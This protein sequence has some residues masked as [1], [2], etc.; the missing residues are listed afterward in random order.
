MFSSN[1]VFAYTC[2]DDHRNDMNQQGWDDDNDHITHEDNHNDTTDEDMLTEN[3][4]D[5]STYRHS[6]QIQMTPALLDIRHFG[7]GRLTNNQQD[8]QAISPPTYT[9][10]PTTT[11]LVVD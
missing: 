7:P 3:T 9:L 6:W 4:V 11:Y 2:D 1:A 8:D 5:E 10:P